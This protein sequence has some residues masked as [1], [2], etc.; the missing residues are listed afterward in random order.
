MVH[1]IQECCLRLNNMLLNNRMLVKFKSI[2]VYQRNIFSLQVF[3]LK[4][5]QNF[6]VKYATVIDYSTVF[7]L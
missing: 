1:L 3:S 5:N 2:K 4:S 7:Y 6:I